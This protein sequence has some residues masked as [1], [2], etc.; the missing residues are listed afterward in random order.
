MAPR[1]A[2]DLA[3]GLGPELDS[4]FAPIR[5]QITVRYCPDVA[6]KARPLGHI[7][8]IQLTILARR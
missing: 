4:T 3:L 7:L 5:S 8:V 1:G 2:H 6:V